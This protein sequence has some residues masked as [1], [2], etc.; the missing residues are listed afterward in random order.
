MLYVEFRPLIG[1]FYC[2]WCVLDILIMVPNI[3]N[4]PY[5]PPP[6]IDL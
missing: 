6:P 1:Q 2:E 5:E 3:L 4:K